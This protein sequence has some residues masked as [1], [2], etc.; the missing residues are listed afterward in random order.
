MLVEVILLAGLILAISLIITGL[1]WQW[2]LT[3]TFGVFPAIAAMNLLEYSIYTLRNATVEGMGPA[4]L[5]NSG[6]AVLLFTPFVRVLASVIFFGFREHNR[7]Y[8]AFTGFVL[9]ILGIVLFGL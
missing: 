5:A 7:I 3:G 8:T 2:I 9:V 4:A 6:I 1:V